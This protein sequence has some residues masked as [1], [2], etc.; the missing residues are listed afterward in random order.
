MGKPGSR[1]RKLVRGRGVGGC[2]RLE[3]G[4]NLFRAKFISTSDYFG[5]RS[6]NLGDLL[7]EGMLV[8]YTSR[9][10]IDERRWCG[11]KDSRDFEE[12]L[13]VS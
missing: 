11:E 5:P 6:S 10:S 9:V 7:A 2:Q 4:V 3:W 13:R 12:R 1:T 8:E